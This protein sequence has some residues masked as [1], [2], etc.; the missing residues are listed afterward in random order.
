MQLA[1]HYVSYTVLKD[2][3]FDS[4]QVLLSARSNALEFEEIVSNAR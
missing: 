2:R 4:F 3:H 1:R